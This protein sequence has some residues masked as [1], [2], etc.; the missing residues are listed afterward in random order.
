M[1][2]LKEFKEPETV[3]ICSGWLENREGDVLIDDDETA[4]TIRRDN[5]T[6]IDV[7]A[8]FGVAYILTKDEFFKYINSEHFRDNCDVDG[9]LYN[10]YAVI[11]DYVGTISVVAEYRTGQ[12][13]DN[14]KLDDYFHHQ[15]MDANLYV[16]VSGEYDFNVTNLEDALKTIDS[17]VSS[18]CE[19]KKEPSL[20]LEEKIEILEGKIEIQAQ[21]ISQ[22]SN[23]VDWCERNIK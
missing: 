21:Q 15:N 4:F 7:E 8:L 16:H 20:S 12:E 18:R 1:R 13:T 9:G 14:F 10:Q 2:V 5:K 6:Y 3:I 23:A 19:L 22:L 11:N 17:G